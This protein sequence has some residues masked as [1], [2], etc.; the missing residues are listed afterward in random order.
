V[1]L[2]LMSVAQYASGEH[3]AAGELLM[4]AA[5]EGEEVAVSVLALML[6]PAHKGDRDPVA[7]LTAQVTVWPLTEGDAAILRGQVSRWGLAGSLLELADLH[8]ALVAKRDEQV[9]V[10]GRGSRVAT[11]L[12]DD[13]PVIA[14][15]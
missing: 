4:L 9:V 13:W 11:Y 7:A 2:D 6:P 14:L 5:D 12:V 3:V 1:I 15:G 8:T 10:T